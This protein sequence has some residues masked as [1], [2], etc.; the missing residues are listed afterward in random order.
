MVSEESDAETDSSPFGTPEQQLQYMTA[1][2][3]YLDA[4]ANISKTSSCTAKDFV[5][6]LDTPEEVTSY[7]REYNLSVHLRDQ[8]TA[9]IKQWR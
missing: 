8:I 3:P 7:I 2:Q 4:N 9:T 6:Y 5:V 1:I